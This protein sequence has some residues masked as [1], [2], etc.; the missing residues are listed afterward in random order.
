VNTPRELDRVGKAAWR[1]AA[2]ILLELGE[3]VDLNASAL[4]AYAHAESVATAVRAQWWAEPK[5]VVKGG[6]GAQ[7]PNPVLRELD[8]V[9]RRVAELRHELG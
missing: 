9:E 6:R 5:A 2:A 3:D 8:R 7:V 4:R 1:E